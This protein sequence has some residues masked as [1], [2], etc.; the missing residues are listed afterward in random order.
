MECPGHV[1]S[2]KKIIT[3]SC[4]WIV[5]EEIKLKMEDGHNVIKL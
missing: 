1:H 2:R 5:T 3:A 4:F